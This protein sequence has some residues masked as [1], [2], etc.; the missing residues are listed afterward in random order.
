MNTWKAGPVTVDIWEEGDE[1]FG[2]CS[3]AGCEEPAIWRSSSSGKRC[4]VHASTVEPVVG[5]H[6]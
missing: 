1:P 4:Q 5:Q 3:I 6:G 2:P